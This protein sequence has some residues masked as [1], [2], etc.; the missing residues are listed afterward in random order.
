LHGFLYQD[1]LLIESIVGI[2]SADDPH[3][4]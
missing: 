3:A 4:V 1:T 2:L